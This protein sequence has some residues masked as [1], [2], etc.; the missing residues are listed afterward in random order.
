MRH[1]Y[2]IR[3]YDEP[4]IEF[5][6]VTDELGGQIPQILSHSGGREAVFPLDLP[7]TSEGLSL[8]LRRRVIPKNREFV[9]QILQTFGLTVD[10]TKGIIDVCKGLSLN[11]SY[12]VAPKEFGGAFAEYNMYEKPFSKIL[13][14][15]AYT[16]VS[17]GDPMFSTSPEL[18]TNGMLPK[19]WRFIKNDG[20]YLFKG[21]TSGA[22]NT[23]NEPY[24]EYYASQIAERMRLNAIHYDLVKWKGILASKCELFT[25]I[26]TAYV[27]IGRIVTSGGLTAA[28]KFYDQQGK[29]FADSIRDMLVFDALIYNTDR[30]FGNFGVL[31]DNRGG[32]IIA[33]APLFDHGMSLF[34]FATQ[35]DLEDLDAYAKTRPSAFE[36]YSFENIVKSIG[37]RRQAEQLREMIGFRFE[38]HPKYNLPETRLK[39]IEAHIQKRVA[40]LIDLIGKP[41]SR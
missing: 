8:W 23:G 11:D 12:W 19:A 30:H 26:N 41:I 28:L 36:N 18:T 9:E 35:K 29:E 13:S 38:R 24:S 25:D 3:L 5:E 27:P 33:P 1:I 15:V 32:D 10:D 4:L 20:I 7:M 16:G 21:G 14:L 34:N 40:R 31:R 22:S 39:A 2:E 17:R 6:F 37:E